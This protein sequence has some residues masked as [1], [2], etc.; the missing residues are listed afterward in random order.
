MLS[1]G[2]NLSESIPKTV[3]TTKPDARHAIFCL[4]YCFFCM[5]MLRR[6]EIDNRKK[7]AHFRFHFVTNRSQFIGATRKLQHIYSTYRC[8]ATYELARVYGRPPPT[9]PNS[10]FPKQ[11]LENYQILHLF[12]L[13]YDYF[14]QN[15]SFSKQ[16]YGKWAQ[17]VV[18]YFGVVILNLKFTKSSYLVH[19]SSVWSEVTWFRSVIKILVGT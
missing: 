10:V 3:L 14:E 18:M 1:S 17:K 15:F 12:C 5:R 16:I 7:W 4:F 11:K 13:S 2:R 8:K 6:Y 19:F 9:M